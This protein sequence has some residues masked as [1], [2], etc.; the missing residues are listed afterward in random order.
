[1]SE[2][3][4]ALS[5]QQR[6]FLSVLLGLL[7]VVPSVRGEMEL[8]FREMFATTG[9]LDAANPGTNFSAVQ[10]TLLQRAGGPRLAGTAGA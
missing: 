9:Q 1:M 5:F 2:T 8:V 3:G 7:A 4:F 10:R 6:L